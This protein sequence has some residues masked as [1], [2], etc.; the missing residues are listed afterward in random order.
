MTP[1]NNTFPPVREFCISS[2]VEAGEA[3]VIRIENR[4]L[5]VALGCGLV[6]DRSGNRASQTVTYPVY[7]LRQEDR[8]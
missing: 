8:A 6:I 3:P 4:H 5:W 7:S 2:F 1:L